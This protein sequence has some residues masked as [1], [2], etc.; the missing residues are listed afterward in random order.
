MTWNKIDKVI[1]SFNEISKYGLGW[2]I[3]GWFYGWFGAIPNFTETG[4]GSSS[5]NEMTKNEG[6]YIEIDK[7]EG[8]WNEISKS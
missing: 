4:K 1:S 2:F 6:N 3:V 8:T 7:N 5:F